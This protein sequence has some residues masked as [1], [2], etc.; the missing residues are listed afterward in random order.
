MPLPK[1][2]ESPSAPP[3][4]NIGQPVSP[5]HFELREDGTIAVERDNGKRAPELIFRDDSRG[6]WLYHGNCL[7]LLD[8]IAAK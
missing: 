3:E 1:L 2:E 6:L 8:A 7:E 5:S 4:N